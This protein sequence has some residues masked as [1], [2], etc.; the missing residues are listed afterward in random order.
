MQCYGAES[1]RKGWNYM[2]LY[3][4]HFV[5]RISSCVLRVATRNFEL[6]P[7]ISCCDPKFRIAYFVLRP[8]ISTY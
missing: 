1:R 7:E 6:R 3:W 2:N 4:Y 5:L 8:E